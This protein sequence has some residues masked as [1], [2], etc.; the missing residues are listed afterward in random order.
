MHISLRFNVG[1]QA[2]QYIVRLKS[3]VTEKH[4]PYML[5]FHT[6]MDV[7]CLGFLYCL[8]Y[9]LTST[10]VLFHSG[11]YCHHVEKLTFG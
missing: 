10:V 9:I 3:C 7:D 11:G 5:T 6:L 1:P 2:S 8:P 4:G